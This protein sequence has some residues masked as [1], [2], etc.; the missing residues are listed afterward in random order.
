MKI[1]A[2]LREKKK[3]EIDGN[4]KKICAVKY[5]KKA[6]INEDKSWVLIM[7]GELK[8]DTKLLARFWQKGIFGKPQCSCC[9]STLEQLQKNMELNCQ[10]DRTI[11]SHIL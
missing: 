2:E 5:S 11:T 9:P 3:R 10:T 7:F 6:T 1:G 4:K 8:A